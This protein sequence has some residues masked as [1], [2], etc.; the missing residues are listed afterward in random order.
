MTVAIM[1]HVR[2]TVAVVALHQLTADAQTCT[3]SCFKPDRCL[4]GVRSQKASGPE[5]SCTQTH[6]DTRALVGP[7]AMHICQHTDTHKH[8]SSPCTAAYFCPATHYS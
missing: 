1:R 2:V 5:E 8:I 4:M 3:V 7:Y 6:A